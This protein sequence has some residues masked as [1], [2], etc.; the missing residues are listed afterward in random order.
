MEK[1]AKDWAREAVERGYTNEEI[2]DLLNRDDFNSEKIEEILLFCD[3]MRQRK[4]VNESLLKEEEIERQ[5]GEYENEEEIVPPK[6]IEEISE[7]IA[8]TKQEVG[9][10]IVGQDEII[11]AFI[12][13]LLCDGHVLIEGIPGIAKTLIVKTLAQASGCSSK[14]IQF[15]VDLL[16]SDILGITT[17][18]PQKGFETI[19]GPIFANFIVADEINRSPPKT[20]SALIECMQE[21]QVT[22][23]KETYKVPLPFFVMA[24]NNPVE[25]SGVYDLPEAQIDRFLFKLLIDYPQTRE[26]KKIMEHNITLQKFEDFD[27]RPVLS[28]QKIIEMQNVTKT[29]YMDDKVKNYVISI[30]EKTRERN[31]KIANYIEWGA[32]PRASIGLFIASK[33]W[34]LMNGRSYV[35]PEDVKAIAH[36]VLRHR[37][38]LN[39]KART[40]GITSDKIIDKIL[41]EVSI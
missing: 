3:S 40:E 35:I 9:K 4:E 28:P 12:C 39:Y 14:R 26:E 11:D 37:I 38:I 15:T 17:Y 22:I 32:S 18:T 20:Q 19:K 24:N 27:I 2:A 6:K 5:E 31:F 7:L 36:Y 41:R 16:P 10:V 34:A 8:E 33:A 13:S 21:K 25:T 30:V 29:I 23:G 1:R